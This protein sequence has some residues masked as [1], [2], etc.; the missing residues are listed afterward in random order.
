MEGWFRYVGM[1]ITI[2]AATR[3]AVGSRGGKVY[4]GLGPYSEF[5]FYAT[6]TAGG[7]KLDLFQKDNNKDLAPM[8]D[9]CSGLNIVAGYE[10]SWGLQ[11]NASGKIG[12]TNVL[13][14]NSGMSIFPYAISVGVGYCFN[15]K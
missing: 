7:T 15:R 13:D 4:V 8:M 3:I 2:F 14:P 6:S 12:F 9:Y 5:G 10:F 11:L 1:E